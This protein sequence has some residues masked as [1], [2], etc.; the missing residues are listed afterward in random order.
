M[1]RRHALSLLS[2]LF[3]FTVFLVQFSNG[4]ACCA[5]TERREFR[6]MLAE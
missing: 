4:L 5:M 3:S 6:E 1:M 2:P